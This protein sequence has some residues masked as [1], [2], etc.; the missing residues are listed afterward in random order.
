MAFESTTGSSHTHQADGAWDA[1][2]GRVGP[3]LFC[4]L[5]SLSWDYFRYTWHTNRDTYDKVVFDE[6]RNN[7]ILAASL[8]YLAS[9]DP[10]FFPREKRL[11]PVNPDSGERRTWPKPR[12]PDRA[13]RLGKAKK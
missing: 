10:E 1:G 4:G 13:G 9:E 8:I 12:N 2:R 6:V 7:V 11:L 5:G 3:C